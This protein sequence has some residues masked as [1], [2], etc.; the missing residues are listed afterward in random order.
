MKYGTPTIKLIEECS[1]LIQVL[2][3]GERFGY[4]DRTPLRENPP[5]NRQRILGEIADVEHAL[6]V[7][8]VW[9]NEL[10]EDIKR[11]DT[12]KLNFAA[13]KSVVKD[14]Q[15]IG[16][17]WLKL[18]DKEL[19]IADSWLKLDWYLHRTGNNTS[20][21]FFQTIEFD[22]EGRILIPA[23]LRNYTCCNLP[24]WYLNQY[25]DCLE[26]RDRP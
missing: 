8:K 13:Y 21:W 6:E 9:L 12:R 26:L 10:P 17:E 24:Q 1:E 16:I 4:D 18:H 2:C 25:Y 7:F 5:T 19:I 22:P 3:K 23:Q 15:V 14:G 11:R 20:E